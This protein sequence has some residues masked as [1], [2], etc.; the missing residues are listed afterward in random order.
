MR[1]YNSAP[2]Q[3]FLLAA[4]DDALPSHHILLAPLIPPS[5]R[6]LTDEETKTLFTKLSHYIGA[7]IVHL[8][9]RDDAP[10]VFRLH[11]D[12]VYYASEVR[13]S[14]G[15]HGQGS[16]GRAGVRGACRT[17]LWLRRASELRH[18]SRL[19]VCQEASSVTSDSQSSWASAPARARYDLLLYLAHTP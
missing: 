11:R 6:P 10:H 16:M 15:Q 19:S 3:R 8:V 14:V 13:A 12:R 9:D 4:A 1:D 7:N 2:L 17:Q 5:M 18:A